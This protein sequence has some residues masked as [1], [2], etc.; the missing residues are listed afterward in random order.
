VICSP[1][2]ELREIYG[3]NECSS[4]ERIEIPSSVEII[5]CRTE[6]SIRGFWPQE[7]IVMNYGFHC[8]TSLKEV[9]FAEDND[10]RDVNGFRGCPSIEQV[11][12]PP[13]GWN[14][15]SCPIFLHHSVGN[16]ARMR[17]RAQLQFSVSIGN[18]IL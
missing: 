18:G 11:D 3:F 6:F 9:I 14:F 7:V 5:G 17:R 16:M 4:L 15:K 10:V 12:N 1:D 13:N 2:S 8:C